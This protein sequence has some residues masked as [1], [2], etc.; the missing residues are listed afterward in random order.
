MAAKVYRNSMQDPKK[1]LTAHGNRENGVV[2]RL[3]AGPV[4]PVA[5]WSKQHLDRMLKTNSAMQE[6]SSELRAANK[7]SSFGGH[8]KLDSKVE[9][10][11]AVPDALMGA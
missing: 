4:P 10:P 8:K 6:R 11:L 1:E 3:L 7:T 9:Q 5:H 2:N